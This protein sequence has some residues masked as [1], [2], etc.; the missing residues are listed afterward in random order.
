MEGNMKT[1]IFEIFR[2]GRHNGSGKGASKE[3]SDEDLATIAKFYAQDTK[4]APLVLSHPADNQPQFGNVKRLIHHKGRLFAEAEPTSE[5]LTKIKNGE[6]SGISASF[7]PPN[8]SGNPIK[9]LGYYLN[10]VGFL[11]KETPA[12]KGMQNPQESI[13]HLNFSEPIEMLYFC[14]NEAVN[15][16]E[17][18]AEKANYF[19][20]ALDIDFGTA[21]NLAKG[22]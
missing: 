19:Q 14:E 5:I 20:T 17:N 22:E 4:N 21:L 18:L 7:Y 16:A 8:H 9:D 3:W 13:S 12:V 2:T 6:I 1:A 10:H 11:E 15:F